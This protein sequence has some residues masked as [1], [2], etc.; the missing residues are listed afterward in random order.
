[1]PSMET[2]DAQDSSYKQEVLNSDKILTIEMVNNA[3]VYS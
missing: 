1:M 3:M 2:F